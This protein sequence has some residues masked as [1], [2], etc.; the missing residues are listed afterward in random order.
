MAHAHSLSS[1]LDEGACPPGWNVNPSAWP[2]RLGVLGLA[3]TGLGLAIYLG[4]FQIHVIPSVWDPYFG[5]GSHEVLLGTTQ[6]IHVSD[7]LIGAFVYLLDFI[8]GAIGGRERWR[9]QPWAILFQGVIVLVLAVVGVLL[10]IVQRV[11]FGAYCTLCL[12]SAACSVLMVGFVAAE[13]LA[14]LQYLHRVRCQGGD[15]RQAFW[16]ERVRSNVEAVA[17]SH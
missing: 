5:E 12:C 14:A 6:V 4:L 17:S 16:G 8:F 15:V 7:A 2:E 9:T 3:A 1:I 13:V 10:T 11:F